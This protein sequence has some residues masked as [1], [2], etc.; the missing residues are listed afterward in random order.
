MARRPRVFVATRPEQVPG[1][2][3]RF[4]SVDGAVP[5]AE[6]T[7]DHHQTGERI[8]LDTLPSAFDLEGFDGIGTTLADTDALA[9]VVALLA[10]GPSRLSPGA[11]AVLECASHHCDHLR[12]HPGHGGRA[13]RLGERLDNHV[14]TELAAVS[15]A[16]RSGRFSRLCRDILRALPGP[17]PGRAA[18]PWAPLVAR[19]EAEGRLS[20]HGGV[21]LVDLRRGWRT[22]VRPDAWYAA[23]PECRAAVVAERHP[24]GGPR[25]T[26]GQNP[27]L[28]DPPD[29]RPVLGALAAAEFARG[30]PALGPEARPGMENWGGRREVG[31]SPWNYGSRLAPGEVASIVATALG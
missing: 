5:G 12:P 29:M 22:P 11:R 31:G 13:N 14:A 23:R 16:R 25:Y 28:A 24:R 3:R 9:S 21:L 4:I 18:P 10:G 8:N 19:A 1:D 20:M 27:F 26:M 2:C 7:W 17:F 6:I 15:P 30:A